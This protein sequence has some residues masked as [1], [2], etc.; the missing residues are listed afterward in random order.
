M[1]ITLTP[2]SNWQIVAIDGKFVMKSLGQAA[3]VFDNLGKEDKKLIAV[4]LNA[5]THMDSSAINFLLGVYKQIKENNGQIV[6][7]GANE[8]I[9][10]NKRERIFTKSYYE[11]LAFYWFCNNGKNFINK[12]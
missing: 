4:D 9:T 8:D 7:F 1:E 11:T 5:T 2:F 6:F 3:K 10:G 12:F